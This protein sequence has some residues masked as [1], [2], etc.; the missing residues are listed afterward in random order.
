MVVSKNKINLKNILLCLIFFSTL[1]CTP[2]NIN[3]PIKLF[4]EKK[5]KRISFASYKEI[6]LSPTEE[7]VLSN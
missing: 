4:D 5:Q 1:A 3:F 2:K 7:D 6:L